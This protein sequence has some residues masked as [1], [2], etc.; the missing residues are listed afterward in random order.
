MNLARIKRYSNNNKTEDNQ[1]LVQYTKAR[2]KNNR[3]Q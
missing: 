3:S 2:L 1:N